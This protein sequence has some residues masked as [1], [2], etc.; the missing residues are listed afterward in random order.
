MQAIQVFSALP[1][2]MRNPL[3]GTVSDYFNVMVAHEYDGP[4]TNDIVTSI[5][6]NLLPN[7][8]EAP[9]FLGARMTN[10]VT[11]LIPQIEVYLGAFPT[12]Y[13]RNAI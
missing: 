5:W 7:C 10:G 4:L 1:Q 3:L 13:T 11:V 9:L 12:K 2:T 6:M 8:N